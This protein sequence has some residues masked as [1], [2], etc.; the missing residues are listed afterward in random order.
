MQTAS[1]H[2]ILS[3]TEFRAEASHWCRWVAHEEGRIWI[4]RHGR[5]AAALVPVAQ[6]RMLER[7]ELRSLDQER[8]RMEAMYARWRRV[9]C[10][11]DGDA[12]TEAF[13]WSA[14]ES[15]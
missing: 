6:C 5:V 12:A 7:F 15:G 9:K 14:Y 3:L 13:A 4:T 11:T 10:A 2:R 1:P 8:A